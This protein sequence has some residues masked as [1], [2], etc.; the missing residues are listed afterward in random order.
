[1]HFEDNKYVLKAKRNPV[2][3]ELTSR[4]DAPYLV[5]LD[6]KKIANDSYNKDTAVTESST[7]GAITSLVGESKLKGTKQMLKVVS[8]V[9]RCEVCE[10]N[11][12]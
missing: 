4:E 12:H 2:Q 11:D 9:T 6:S 3:C 5:A 1:M 8:E 10:F 7:F